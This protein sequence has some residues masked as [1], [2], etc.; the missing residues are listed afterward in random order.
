ML[1]GAGN[2]LYL[3]R[4][5]F[6]DV[7]PYHM[8]ILKCLHT[9][10]DVTYTVTDGI[11]LL[12]TANLDRDWSAEKAKILGQLFVEHPD[13][14][15]DPSKWEGLLDTYQLNDHHWAWTQKARLYNSAEF[16]WFY[17]MADGQVQAACIIKHPKESRADKAGIFYVDYLAVAYWNRRRDGYVRRFDGVGTKLLIHA[18]N[19]SI[20]VLGYRPGFSL[21]SLP[22]SEGYYQNLKMTDFGMDQS[23]QNLRYFEASEPVALSIAQGAA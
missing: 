23:Y 11:D 6:T 22:S 21:H 18:I 16:F 17:L 2:L 10:R 4:E 3:C 19:Y 9:G 15:S 7:R 14:L 8:Q 5:P 20:D 13:A 12:A 1:W